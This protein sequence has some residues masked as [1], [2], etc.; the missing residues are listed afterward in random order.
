MLTLDDKDKRLAYNY[1][2]FVTK[3]IQDDLSHGK[4]TEAYRKLK[5]ASEEATKPWEQEA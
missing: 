3:L 1:L 5:V 2:G 4:Y